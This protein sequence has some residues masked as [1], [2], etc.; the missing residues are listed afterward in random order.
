MIFSIPIIVGFDKLFCDRISK[1]SVLLN[2][3]LDF[4]FEFLIFFYYGVGVGGEEEEAIRIGMVLS[5]V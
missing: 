4:P 5:L 2:Q 1:F 3:N